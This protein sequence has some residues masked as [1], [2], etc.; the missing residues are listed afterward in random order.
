ME[1][2]TFE[3]QYKW[4]YLEEKAIAIADMSFLIAGIIF[5]IGSLLKTGW[6]IPFGIFVCTVYIYFGI[7]SIMRWILLGKNNLSPVSKK[8]LPVYVIYM[9]LFVIFGF[10]GLFY[11]W[12]KV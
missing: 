1:E 12:S 3:P 9:L 2:K 10:F 4:F 5:V 7:M 11:L 6:T 8:Q